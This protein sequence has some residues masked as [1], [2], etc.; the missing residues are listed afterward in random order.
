MDTKNL[1]EYLT[2]ISNKNLLLNIGMHLLIIISI[3]TIYLLKDM[4]VKRCIVSSTLLALFLSVTITAIIYGNPFHAITFG[5]MTL[6]AGF[7]VIKSKNILSIPQKS[8]QTIV[9]FMFILIGLWYPEFVKASVFEHFIISP[10]G[11]V[12]CPTLITALGILNLYYPNVNKRQFVVTVFFGIIYGFIGT[13]KLGVYL[14][15]FLVGVVIY[16]I[17]NMIN[18]RAIKGNDTMYKI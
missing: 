5:I 17:Y 14:D 11:V 8:I 16:S 10:V 2:I 15:L 12:P 4:K 6:V 1:L 7:V 18:G 9:A 3:A 13:F